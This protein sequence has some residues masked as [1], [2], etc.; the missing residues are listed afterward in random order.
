MALQLIAPY[1]KYLLNV[2]VINHASVIGHLRQVLNVFAAKPE[3]SKF[4]IGITGDVKSRLASHQ[5]HK[6]SFSLMCPIYE[7][8]GNLVENAFDRLEREAIRN[9]R[10]GITHPETGKLLLQCSNGPGGA[11]PKNT[12]YILVG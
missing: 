1:E 5:A 12:L 2:G 11:R 4:Y 9:F 8:A 3:Y 6:P 10:G 7:E